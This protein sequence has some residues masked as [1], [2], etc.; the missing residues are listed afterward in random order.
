MTL[1][2]NSTSTAGT[3]LRVVVGARAPSASDDINRVQEPIDGARLG[4]VEVGV[5]IGTA[6]GKVIR[7][8][9]RVD[10]RPARARS[11]PRPG[12]PRSRRDQPVSHD[13][14]AALARFLGMDIS[15]DDD[16]DLARALSGAPR[17]HERRPPRQASGQADTATIEVLLEP[18]P[19]VPGLGLSA[20]LG[21]AIARALDRRASESDVLARAMAWKRI[22]HGEPS[23]SMRLS[24]RAAAAYFVHSW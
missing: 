9:A 19:R 3:P 15:E 22:F 5:R 4:I 1:P 23:V 11:G 7:R 6:S 18:T 12:R 10:V 24:P 14:A 17:R 20:A 16:H 21:V 2:A 8:R 13:D